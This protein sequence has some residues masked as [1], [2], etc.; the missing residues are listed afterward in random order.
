M[1]KLKEKEA[2]T[3]SQEEVSRE[4]IQEAAYYHWLERGCPMGDDLTDW[5]EV[6]KKFPA[7]HHHN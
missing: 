5:V 2:S 6:E 3:K 7:S 4:T 1:A